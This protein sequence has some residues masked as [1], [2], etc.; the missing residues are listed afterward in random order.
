L[1]VEKLNPERSPQ[2]A[3]LVQIVLNL[4]GKE[5]EVRGMSGLRMK[6]VKSERVKVKF[7]LTVDVVEREERLKLSWSYNRELWDEGRMKRM[8]EH[9]RNLARAMVKEEK[10]RIEELPLLS[11]EEQRHLLCEWKGKG[12]EYGK[13]KCLH[14]L[15]EEQAKRNPEGVAVV[16][17]D[18]QVSY[19]E[20][21]R[22][23]NQL[24]H[25]LRGEGVGPDRLVGLCVERSLEMVVGIVGILKAG[26][27][28]VPLDPGYPRERLE[29]MLRDS[30][31]AL[32]VTE[33]GVE[34][35]LPEEGMKKLRLDGDAELLRRESVENP[36]RTEVGVKP[37]HLAYVIYTSGSTGRPKGVM[38]EHRQVQRL[39]A[40][41]EGDFGFGEQDV[42]TLFHS[43]AF[44]FSVW[45]MEGGW[46]WYRNG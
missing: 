9:F 22:R 3:P 29:Y 45:D 18:R 26:G 7:D 11:E 41:T 37:E 10:A 43:Y 6:P 44:D 13:E 35:R 8:G 27:A 19:G 5:E 30:R 25:Y 21:N 24:A 28:Y 46:W 40:A 17:E 12:Q 15:L 1:V 38:V 33:R 14:E 32:V 2:Y 23:A 42:W 31:P 4:R 36:E 16:Y 39:L 34:E 20:L